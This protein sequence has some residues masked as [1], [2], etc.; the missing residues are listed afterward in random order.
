MELYDQISYEFS[1]SLTRRYSTSFSLGIHMLD[2][3]F[4]KSI[5]AIYGF[6]RI[7]DEIVDTFHEH[8]KEKL[9]NRFCDDTYLAL[10]QKISTNPILNAFQDTVNRFD[11]DR[12][13]IDAFLKSMRMDLSLSDCN[14][15]TY[16]EYIYGSA[17]VVGLMCL[18]V[19]CQDEIHS[20]EKLTTPARQLG[21]A[22][23][24]INFLRDFKSDF[25]DRGR[26]YFPGIDF[27]N[28]TNE[29]KTEIENDIENEFKQAW[30]GVIQLPKGSKLGV[31]VAYIYYLT[32]FKKIK[33]IPAARIKEERI[34][35]NNL[36]KIALLVQT[37]FRYK[38]KLV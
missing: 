7:A 36:H 25:A 11:I 21:S 30:N 26:I 28:F 5:Y 34:R 19:F 24:K 20:Y 4:H 38:L 23:Q 8:D 3:K 35:V 27:T 22:F 29:Q 17:E 32:L 18:K 31:M 12:N 10:D 2:S 16:K 33:L 6:V 9:F 37:W 15:N 1:R 14:E 13:L